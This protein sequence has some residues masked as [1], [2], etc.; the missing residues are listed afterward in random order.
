M[1]HK[2]DKLVRA[3]AG[4]PR[5]RRLCALE[6]A[7]RARSTD[8]LTLNGFPLQLGAKSTLYV[9]IHRPEGRN[10]ELRLFPDQVSMPPDA[11]A[12]LVHTLPH[13]VDHSARRGQQ[14]CYVN[15]IYF[16]PQAALLV[17]TASVPQ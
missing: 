10:L 16:T 7:R 3:A 17:C 2:R 5:S 1:Q 14:A 11:S 4:A 15:F 6:S 12:A 8:R 13:A 9:T